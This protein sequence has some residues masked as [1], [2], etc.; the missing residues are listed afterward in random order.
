MRYLAILLLMAA[1]GFSQEVNIAKDTIELENIVVEKDN[2]HL[3]LKT[4]KLTGP[5]F[6]PEGMSE[7]A[8]IITL[9]RD[10]PKG[11]LNAVT[12]YFNELF[13]DKDQYGKFRDTEFELVIYKVAEDDTPGEVITH[14]TQ[15]I[16]VA[17]EARGRVKVYLY[18]LNLQ[19]ERSVFV[20][21]KRITGTLKN[22]F[23]L[24]CLCNG[25]YKYV[26]LVR[27]EDTQNW[28]RRWECAALKIDVSVITGK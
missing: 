23:F 28:K 12:F 26:T 17:K 13:A 20:G 2:R 7:A 27:S 19:G 10:L 14:D 8:E 3:K 16:T 5:C 21:L 15:P 4:I 1:S 18:G 24:S 9:V 25:Q 6:Y 11:D 22:E